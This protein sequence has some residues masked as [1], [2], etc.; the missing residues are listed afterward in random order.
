[1]VLSVYYLEVAL[2]RPVS[3]D[4]YPSDSERNQISMRCIGENEARK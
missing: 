3:S 4:P 1:M 2:L